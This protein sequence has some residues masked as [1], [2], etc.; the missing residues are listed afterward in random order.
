MYNSLKET[1]DRI[2]LVCDKRQKSCHL[3]INRACPRCFKHIEGSTTTQ[4]RALANCCKTSPE[5]CQTKK[6][7]NKRE[8]LALLM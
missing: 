1:C 3:P 6:R 8:S 5:N 7:R 4:C 2:L